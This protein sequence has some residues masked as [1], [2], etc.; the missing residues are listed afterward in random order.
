VQKDLLP[1]PEVMRQLLRSR[2]SIR[3]Y[4]KAPVPHDLLADLI[5]TA[6]Y[7]PTGSNRQQVYW[8]VFENPA[9]MKRFAAM[10]IDFMR[11]NLPGIADEAMARSISRIITAWDNG[12]DRILRGAPNLII[13]HSP[14]NLPLADADCVVAL[15]YLE[16]YAYAKGLGTCWCGYFAMAANFY[17]PL[18]EALRLPAGHQCYGAIMLGYPKHGYKSIPQRNSPLLTWR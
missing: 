10:V 1:G 8:T 17:T 14:G 7:A 2:R 5:D 13:V 15:T 6:R 3:Q 4:K 9:E 11:Q 16:L 18:I 12:K